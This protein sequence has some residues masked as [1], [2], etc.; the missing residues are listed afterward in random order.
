MIKRFV[1]LGAALLLA[2]SPLGATGAYARHHG[3]HHEVRPHGGG[4]QVEVGR[5][6]VR[7]EGRSH[8]P[9]H[10]VERDEHHRPRH[11]VERGE[12][13]GPRHPSCKTIT[14]EDHHGTHIRI[15]CD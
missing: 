3:E 15:E 12:H 13:N 4:V 6:G 1:L 7:V 9:R 8:R 5:G 2:T 11:R 10:R 14:V